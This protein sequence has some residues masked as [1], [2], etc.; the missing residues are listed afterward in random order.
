M[1]TGAITLYNPLKNCGYI[2]PDDGSSWIFISSEDIERSG[3][4]PIFSGKRVRFALND[5]EF[6]SPADRNALHAA[7]KRRAC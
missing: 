3:I 5:P 2:Q 6:S 1:F 4:A 7:G